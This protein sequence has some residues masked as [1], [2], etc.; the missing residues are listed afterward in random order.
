MS[1]SSSAAASQTPSCMSLLGPQEGLE[2][3][4]FPIFSKETSLLWGSAMLHFPQGTKLGRLPGA[5]VLIPEEP[6]K[7][8]WGAPSSLQLLLSQSLRNANGAD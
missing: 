5:A 3:R 2:I 6:R 8:L 4:T 1:G 7:G